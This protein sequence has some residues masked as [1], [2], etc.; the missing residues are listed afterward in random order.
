MKIWFPT[1]RAGSGSDVFVRQLA[2][3][4]R[5]YGVDVQVTWFSGKYEVY[6][7][8]LKKVPPPPGTS[9]V[10]GN[11]WAGFAFK[12]GRV[13]LVVTEFHNVISQ[14]YKAYKSF[15]QRL[16]HSA[17]IRRYMVASLKAASAV[18]AISEYTSTDLRKSIECRVDRVIYPFFDIPRETVD[19]STPTDR[20]FRLLFVGNLSTRKGAD[21]LVPIMQQLGSSFQLE[22]TS[23]LRGEERIGRTNNMVALG[24]CSEEEL[25]A[26]YRRC[27][28]VLFPTRFEGFGYAALEGMSF[29]KPVVA[30]DNSAL[31]EVV[32]NGATGL[33]CPTGDVTAFVRACRFLAAN[34]A[35]RQS[36]GIAGAERARRLFSKE[37]I[38]PQYIK[39]YE[40]LL[41]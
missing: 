15:A 6:P 2:S 28:A 7:S 11:T 14:D 1:I 25:F 39:L 35:L 32:V 21:L 16:Y 19:E 13:P 38:I 24:H 4:L 8:L 33:L 36:F 37:A 3:S 9:I 26:A 41:N 27:D 30:S 22:Y 5:A 10:H 40:S 20:K 17:L 23:G 12:R 18:T 34:P 31:P 29:G